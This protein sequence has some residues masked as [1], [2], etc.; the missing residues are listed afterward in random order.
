LNIK[1]CGFK[2]S[3][4]NSSMPNSS[5]ALFETNRLRVTNSN[6]HRFACGGLANQLGR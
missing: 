3:S 4:L 6:N 5:G 2:I 1:P